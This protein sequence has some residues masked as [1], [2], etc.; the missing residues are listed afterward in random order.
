MDVFRDREKIFSVLN[1]TR[2]FRFHLPTC[3]QLIPILCAQLWITGD[4]ATP[5]YISQ[6]SLV[7]FLFNLGNERSLL[8]IGRCKEGRNYWIFLS[9]F[10]MKSLA[11][12][13]MS[14][15]NIGLSQCQRFPCSSFN[16]SN[17]YF[18]RV[19]SKCAPELWQNY[20]LI[21]LP[22]PRDGY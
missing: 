6:T 2:M 10:L 22:Y 1:V 20:L 19:I 17:I 8:E 5:N 14:G 15:G 3:I 12:V 16:N 13:I 9:V 11:V 7:D 18:H 4:W 21:D